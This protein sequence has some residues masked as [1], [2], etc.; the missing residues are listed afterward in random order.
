[1]DRWYGVYPAVVTQTNDS[2]KHEGRVKLKLPW[3]DETLETGW[4]RI[5]MPGAGRERGL[6][7][8]PEVDD[9]VMVAFWAGDINHPYVLGGVYSTANKPP[10]AETPQASGKI[11]ERT[12]KTRSGHMIRLA[13]DEADN[14]GEI[15][16][17]FHNDTAYIKISDES[18]KTKIDIT[19]TEG[20]VVI[21]SKGATTVTS[22]DKVVVNATKDA[23]INS[24]ANIKVKTGTGNITVETSSGNAT[25]KGMNVTVEAGGNLNLKATGMATLEASGILTLKGSLVKIN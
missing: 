8:L 11:T 14:K 2:E 25:V 5:I 17:K 4:A 3:L 19:T 21:N 22:Q 12:F 15:E 6:Y 24:D 10:I 20:E 13:E 16:L 1:M 7:W 9:E 18:G 23:E